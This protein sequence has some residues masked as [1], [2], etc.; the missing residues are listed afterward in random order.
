MELKFTRHATRRM[1]AQSITEAMV[2][3]VLLRPQWTPQVHSLNLR[4]DAIVDGARL[5][6]IVAPPG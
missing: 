6:V 3:A 2:E 4:Y 5:A 1:M